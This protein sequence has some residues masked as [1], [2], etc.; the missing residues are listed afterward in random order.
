MVPELDRISADG[1]LDGLE[2]R[3]ID[4]LRTMRAKC[5][6]LENASS[7]VRRFAQA[8]IDMARAAIDRDHLSELPAVLAGAEATG[9]TPYSRPPNGYEPCDEADQ[10]LELLDGVVEPTRLADI[11]QLA[12]ADIES[13]LDQ[14]TA[15]ERQ[16]SS[17]RST[18]H[19]VLDALQAE[20]ARR[21]KVGEVSPD[22]LIS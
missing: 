7:Y 5:H 18:L 12:P 16:L 1:Y 19:R 9:G 21:Y 8:R 2:Q 3:P 11:D 4:E 20:I 10:M 22:A 14:L 15:F 13:I 6:R 17:E